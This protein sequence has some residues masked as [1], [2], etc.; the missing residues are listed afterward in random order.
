MMA[1]RRTQVKRYGRGS[2]WMVLLIAL[3]VSLYS[4]V[5]NPATGESEFSLLSR[6]DEIELGRQA[7]AQIVAQYGV[8]DDDQ[9][10]AYVDQMG[11]SIA[12]VSDDPSLDYTFRVLDSP[13]IN[14]FA[15]PGG[16]IYVTRGLLAYLQNDAQLAMVLGHEIGHVTARHSANQ[17]TNSQLA[18][19]G[20]GLGSVLF[21]DIQPFIGAIDLGLQLLFLKYSRDDE[22]QA[23]ELGVEYATRAGYEAKEGSKFFETLERIQE[24]QGAG[25]P[26][27]ASTHPDPADRKGEIIRLA[28]DWEQQLP[29]IQLRGINPEVYI[30]RLEGVVFGENPRHGFVQGG[31]FYHPDLT[32]QFPV[33]S[34]WDIVNYAAQV[35]MAPSSGEAVI[36]F[37]TA[38][39]STPSAAA[40]N[41]V[42][43]SGAQVLE[44]SSGSVNG[45]S[46]YV[47]ESRIETDNGQGGTAFLRVLSYFIQKGGNVYVF[48]GYTEQ[49]R[50]SS[51][52]STF[53]TV[54]DGFRELTNSSILGVQPFR[55]DAFSAASS[56]TFQSLVSPN[57]GAGMDVEDLAIM[58]QTQVSAQISAGTYLK[59]VE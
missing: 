46:S 42:Q 39:E 14:A 4:C 45:Y 7:D 51:Y 10:A 50:F 52:R 29:N 5:T 41:F 26:T 11:Q 49:S 48:H 12:A 53:T 58:N 17:Y 1:G 2:A 57:S 18:Q 34:N 36:I 16:Y 38:T 6:E 55:V 27:W 9:L 47:V 28:A 40:G 22:S 56:G 33:P 23:D 24:Q 44:S 15:L 37:T 13:V 31:F 30:P 19:L 8:Y 21:E 3:A 25:L 59:E 43:A 32:F 20:L 54:F 35:Q